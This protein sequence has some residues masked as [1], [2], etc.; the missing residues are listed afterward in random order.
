MYPP[1]FDA[2][3]KDIIKSFLT[4]DLTRRLG[5][6]YGGSVDVM[7]HTWFEGVNWHDVLEKRIQS[8]IVPVSNGP[9]DTRNFEEYPEEVATN[10]DMQA[11]DPFQHY[12]VVF[13]V[14][15]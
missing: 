6:L 12:F 3:A 1:H 10:H 8:P 13:V 2:N 11:L 7:N 5:N 15:T 14:L 9:G 4:A